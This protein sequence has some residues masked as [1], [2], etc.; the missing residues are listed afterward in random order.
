LAVLLCRRGHGEDDNHAGG[1][2]HRV[3]TPVVVPHPR[4]NNWNAC[5][6]PKA[7]ACGGCFTKS[8]SAGPGGTC[9]R[10]NALPEFE[11]NYS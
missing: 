3:G 6:V 8:G 7:G 2:T 10:N 1:A 9:R 5:P 11:K 4:V